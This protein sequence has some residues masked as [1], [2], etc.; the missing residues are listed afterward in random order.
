MRPTTIKYLI[1]F[2]VFIQAFSVYSQK[3]DNEKNVAIYLT[4]NGD[5]LYNGYILKRSSFDSTTCLEL[6]FDTINNFEGSRTKENYIILRTDSFRQTDYSIPSFWTWFECPL[7]SDCEYNHDNNCFS[8]NDFLI[9]KAIKNSS[10]M[11]IDIYIKRPD[12]EKGTYIG[13]PEIKMIIND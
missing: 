9:I 12:M 8:K 1:P 3:S 6:A 5:S 13:F 10:K 4:M 2:F 7:A 11:E